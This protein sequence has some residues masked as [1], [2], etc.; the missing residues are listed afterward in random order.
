MVKKTKTTWLFL[1]ETC[2]IIVQ[3]DSLNPEEWIE[4]I[5]NDMNSSYKLQ[6]LKKALPD[7]ITALQKVI[8]G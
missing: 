7:F 1:D 4:I 8:D 5:I 3:E 2:D 6:F